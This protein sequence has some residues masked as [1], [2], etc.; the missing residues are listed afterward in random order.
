MTPS[1]IITQRTVPLSELRLDAPLW[2][3]PREFS[4]LDTK[5]ITAMG[6]SVKS[7]GIVDPLKVQRIILDGGEI[8]TL[9]IDG[10][11]RVLGAREF[12]SKNAPIPVVDI[13]DEP[14][15]LTPEKADELLLKALTTLE[16]ES[17]SSFELS[18]VAERM[19]A[20]GHNGEY[21][22]EAIG[23]S[24]TWV[25]RFL[26]ARAGASP[27][28]LLKWRKGDITDEQFKELAEVKD[29]AKQV[30]AAKE[31]VQA[32]KDGDK[33]EARMRSKEIKETARA[34]AKPVNGANGHSHNTTWDAATR[35]AVV[36]GPQ[37]SLLKE[38]EPKE[39]VKKQ[40]VPARIV[41][42]EMVALETKRAPVSE[43]VK[44]IM[45]GV[46]YA[47]GLIEPDKFGKAWDQYLSRIE[48]KPRKAAKKAKRKYDNKKLAATVKA[49]AKAAKKAKARKP[50]KAGAKR[51]R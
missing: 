49:S 36:K 24:T 40:A 5:Q 25:S 4:G 21:I 35:K 51:K 43:L 13:E 30:E 1:N 29:E 46:K 20:R 18:K 31:V 27:G 37:L 2:S 23:K 39:K 45:I 32:R 10:Q 28:L 44:G 22:A 34:E 33:G 26:K 14:C 47:I 42:E 50:A 41:L 15:E 16:R 7:K 48:G 6:E 3:N 12:L 19:K 11:R 9:V 17:L 38:D 8:I